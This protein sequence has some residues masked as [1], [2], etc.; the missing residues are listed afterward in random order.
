MGDLYYNIFNNKS[1][2]K[3]NLGFFLNIYI[4]NSY[5]SVKV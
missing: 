4:E 1:V 5:F 3:F 2:E